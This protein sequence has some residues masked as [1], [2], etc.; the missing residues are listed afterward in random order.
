MFQD[1]AEDVFGAGF[2]PAGE[3]IANET[4]QTG[5]QQGKGDDREAH[6][7]GFLALPGNVCYIL[8]AGEAVQRGRGGEAYCGF[9]CASDYKTANPAQPAIHQGGRCAG[10][11]LKSR[12]TGNLLT[13]GG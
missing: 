10:S 13:Q 7:P 9:H 3:G 8:N 5:A 6:S 2:H 11:R 1:A 12:R 4:F